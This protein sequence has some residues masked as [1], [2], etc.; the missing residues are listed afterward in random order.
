MLSYNCL[1]ADLCDPRACHLL[2]CHSPPEVV[3]GVFGLSPKSRGTPLLL[4]LYLPPRTI[5]GLRQ[6]RSESGFPAFPLQTSPNTRFFRQKNNKQLS[7]RTGF[8]RKKEE[9]KKQQQQQLPSAKNGQSIGVLSPFPPPQVP[10]VD[11]EPLVGGPQGR[12]QRG[13]PNERTGP[14]TSR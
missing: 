4:D 3:Y 11:V 8:F 5:S 13:F 1:E 10:E 12:N 7:P 14:L 9:D 6:A 2:S